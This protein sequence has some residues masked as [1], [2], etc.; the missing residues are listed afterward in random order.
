MV[1]IVA[2][3]LPFVHLVRN[4]ARQARHRFGDAQSGAG[5][6][7]ENFRHPACEVITSDGIIIGGHAAARAAASTTGE[8]LGWREPF[9][10][11]TVC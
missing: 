10:N 4:I 5:N 9:G 2:R 11:V 7:A 1:P 8:P 3:S 6:Q